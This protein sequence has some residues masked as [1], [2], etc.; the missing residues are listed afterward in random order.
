MGNQSDMS[1]NHPVLLAKYCLATWHAGQNVSRY[2]SRDTFWPMK[3]YD[4]HT[5]LICLHCLHHHLTA[6]QSFLENLDFS[7]KSVKCVF[8]VSVSFS[9][10]VKATRTVLYFKV[11]NSTNIFLASFLDTIE[12]NLT[13]PRSFVPWDCHVH[14]NTKGKFPTRWIKSWKTR[15]VKGPGKRACYNG[16]SL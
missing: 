10:L 15:D 4:Q 16:G 12:E 7:D 14:P 5:T 6:V 13:K 8:T 1:D 11:G 2:L 3:S 9:Y